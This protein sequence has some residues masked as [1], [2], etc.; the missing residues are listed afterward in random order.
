[1][2]MSIFSGINISGSRIIAWVME[3]V[4]A[5]KQQGPW[6]TTTAV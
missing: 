2:A 1:M 3:A 6:I 4:S 5:D